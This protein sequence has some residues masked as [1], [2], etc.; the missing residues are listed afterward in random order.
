MQYY[1]PQS[2]LKDQDQCSG[3][4]EVDDPF[5]DPDDDDEEVSELEDDEDGLVPHGPGSATT[6]L[7][8]TQSKSV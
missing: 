1:I 7:Y 5:S 3:E 8:A 6:L 2:V 4:P